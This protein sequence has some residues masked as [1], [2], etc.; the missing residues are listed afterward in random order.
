MQTSVERIDGYTVKLTV[1][2]SVE[3]VDKAID[4]AYKSI[5]KKVKIPGFRA[6]KAPKP[7]IDTHF[8]REAIVAEAQEGL[9]SETYPKALDAENLRPVQQPEMDEMDLMN[10]GEEFTYVATVVVRPELS[11]SSIEG[12]E[13]TVP[14]TE[15]SEREIDSQIEHLRSRYATL[16]PVEDRGVG[17]DDFVLLSFVG[18]VDGEPYEGNE[19]DKYLYEMGRGLMPKEFEEGVLGLTPGGTTHVE[20]EVPDTSSNPEFVGKTAGFDITVHEIKARV[21]PDLD[22]DFAAT[23]GGYDSLADMRESIRSQL[24]RSKSV[25]AALAREREAR[26]ALAERLEGDIPE[27]MFESARDGMRRDF[28]NSLES[29]GITFEQYL[30]MSGVDFEQ[31]D[32]DLVAQAD[33]SVREELALEALFRQ[34]GLE[35]TDADVDAALLEIAGTGED[36]TESVAEIRARWE[37]AGVLAAVREQIMHR[38]AV[39]W[40]LDDANVKVTQEVADAQ[41]DT[42]TEE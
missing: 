37:A 21:L 12:L 31:L 14:P 15:A 24:N 35:V 26:R 23:A 33:Q 32:G 20:F 22:D 25:G 29:R 1:T 30:E 42:K 2:C 6:G 11:L 40:L 13:I 4:G 19:V 16:E 36:N 17:A 39:E 9:V 7:V 3:E 8:G 10:A 5:A 18:T 27:A 28:S 41:S 34:L 38:K